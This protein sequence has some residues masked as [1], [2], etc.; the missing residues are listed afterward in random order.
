MLHGTG[1]QGNRETP[2]TPR[3]RPDRFRPRLRPASGVLLLALAFGPAG[4][5]SL[6]ALT[7]APNSAR[8]T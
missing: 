3:T 7:P 2:M 6:P 8:F 4:A 1:H 5:A